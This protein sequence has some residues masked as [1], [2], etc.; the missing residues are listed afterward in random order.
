MNVNE[1]NENRGNTRMLATRI[2]AVAV[3]LAMIL[4]AIALCTALQ[5]LPSLWRRVDLSRSGMTDISDETK[6]FLADLD[7]D[8]TIYWLRDPA[9]ADDRVEMFLDCYEMASD[10]V[11]V[12]IRDLDYF[13]ELLGGT[14]VPDEDHY[15]VVQSAKRQ[16]VETE[17]SLYHYRNALIDSM[18]GREYKMTVDE[19]NQYASLFNES[20][21][22]AYWS[23][24]TVHF[25]GE[26][27]LT[28]MIDSVTADIS[29]AYTLTGHG[30]AELVLTENDVALWEQLGLATETLDL[31][32]AGAMPADAD[33]L[34][35]NAPTK[36]LT[37]AECDMILGYMKKGGSVILVTDGKSA[38][39]PNLARIGAVYGLSAEQ[40]TVVDPAYGYHVKDEPSNIL[41]PGPG[42]HEI[43][44]MLAS[45]Y[46]A[47]MPNAHGIQIA[48]S[49]PTGVTAD[50]VLSTS[51]DSFLLSSDG[52]PSEPAIYHVAVAAQKT[53][54]DAS[55][56]SK[57][58]KLVWFSSS[59]A[60]GADVIK[61]TS[62]KYELEVEVTADATEDTTEAATE[63]ADAPAEET[64]AAVGEEPDATETETEAESE[65]DAESETEIKEYTEAVGNSYY[66]AAS[67]SWMTSRFSSEYSSI[68]SVQ[69]PSLGSA[70][71]ITS[72]ILPVAWGIVTVVLIPIGVLAAGLLG[73]MY[74]RRR[75][76]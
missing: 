65:T 7:E 46:L 31:G 1:M 29:K 12:K 39:F 49:L 27:L 42:S 2:R 54:T 40:G 44:T 23:S 14:E 45:Y 53:V 22:E 64:E 73:R 51:E 21:L 6:K 74:Y 37:D 67:L 19:V 69:Q 35:I 4:L 17:S 76:E 68:P 24:M 28:S 33:R 30:E 32:K 66:M 13:I 34:I 75:R 61:Q 52:Q 63:T 25:H 15:I 62:A 41:L 9:A 48:D 43:A 26:A 60:F 18:A 56:E 38:A 55:G 72:K 50:A 47:L 5:L 8:V 10:H 58:A 11:T 57:T 59:E 71:T 3:V 70:L 36:D 20:Q 16:V